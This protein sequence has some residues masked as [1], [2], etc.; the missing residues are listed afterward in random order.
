MVPAGRNASSDGVYRH[1]WKRLRFPKTRFQRLPRRQSSPRRILYLT[2]NPFLKDLVRAN[3]GSA[4]ARVRLGEA[5]ATAG[6]TKQALE[7]LEAA[8]TLDPNHT[9]AYVDLGLIAID[10][11]ELLQAEGYFLKV[12]ELTEGAEFEDVNQRREIALFYLGEIALDDS[13]YEDAIT[14]FKGAL[15]IRRDASDTYYLL[16][17]AYRGLNEY[18]AALD[19]LQTA[20][21]FDPNY[22]EAHFLIGEILMAQDDDINAA[23]HFKWAADLVPDADPPAEALAAIGPAEQWLASGSAALSE[24]DTDKALHDAIMAT[25][26]DPESVDAHKLH[27]TVLEDIGDDAA[28]LESWEKAAELAPEDT[29]IQDTIDRLGGV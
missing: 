24:G 5:M 7:Q 28:A 6:L 21:L 12:V 23:I 13:R 11:S 27:G 26:L 16:A 18:D 17:Q 20:T 22:P 14:Y 19:Q 29:E 9:G 1:I 15:R 10:Q 3:P 4:A 2:R 25:V 8:L